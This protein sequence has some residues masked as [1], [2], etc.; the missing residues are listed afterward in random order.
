MPTARRWTS[1]KL[2][3]YQTNERFSIFAYFYFSSFVIPKPRRTFPTKLKGGALCKKV[4]IAQTAAYN[5]LLQLYCWYSLIAD[6]SHAVSA[7]RK[8]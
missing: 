5:M 2:L 8:V 7:I 1:F 3:S 4:H 6:I